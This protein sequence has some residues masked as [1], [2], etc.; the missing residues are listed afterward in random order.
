MDIERFKDGD[1]RVFT[2]F[3]YQ[4]FPYVK[5]ICVRFF[6][7]PADIED[8]IQDIFYTIYKKRKLVIEE[9]F[10]A[11][12]HNISKNMCINKYRWKKRKRMNRFI[13]PD[14]L[15]IERLISMSGINKLSQQENRMQLMECVNT[16]DGMRPIFSR[17][18]YLTIEGYKLEEI[19]G[20][21]K[22]P[23]GT[24]KTRVHRARK[25]LEKRYEILDKGN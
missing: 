4:Y 17:A 23:L 13:D 11:W 9:R 21:E 2:E 3:Y 19:A 16:I 8:V 1:R 18:L 24:A 5:N 7:N 6:K 22:I 15:D 14:I 10:D 20:I 12:I 25:I